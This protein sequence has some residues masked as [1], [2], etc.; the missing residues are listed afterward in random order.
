MRSTRGRL[1]RR[2]RARDNEWAQLALE[3]GGVETGAGAEPP[4][5]HHANPGRTTQRSASRNRPASA[6]IRTLPWAAVRRVMKGLRALLMGD[7]P[8]W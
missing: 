6:H 2:G 3:L 8:Q 1:L 7:L 4:S 5:D